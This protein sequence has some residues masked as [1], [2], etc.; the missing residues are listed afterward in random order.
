MTK[1]PPGFAVPLAAVA[2][3]LAVTRDVERL[4][5]VR[6][7]RGL[8]IVVGVVALWLVPAMAMH[9][10]DMRSMIREELFEQLSGTGEYADV[11]HQP[12]FYLIPYLFLK[13]APWSP[14]LVLGLRDVGKNALAAPRSLRDD[15]ALLLACWLVGGLV[16]FLFPATKRPDHL[17]P[18]YAPA[19][20]LAGAALWPWI[21]QQTPPVSARVLDGVARLWALGAGA[22]AL[23]LLPATRFGATASHASPPGW[24]FGVSAL[25]LL[26]M[27]HALR[28]SATPRARLIA[29][30]AAHGLATLV[31]SHSLTAPA[32]EADAPV[33]RAFAGE[34]ARH[35]GP[36]PILFVETHSIPLQFLLARNVPEL[37]RDAV[38]TTLAGADAPSWLIAPETVLSALVAD[39]T[40][41][42][43]VARW[44]IVARSSPRPSRG[45]AVLALVRIAPAAPGAAGAAEATANENAAK[46]PV[47]D[48][49]EPTNATPG[50]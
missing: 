5:S 2:L 41:G 44:P 16:V 40:V 42:D 37:S 46:R 24:M 8:A 30:L 27:A 25:A 43:R 21:G 45:G 1:G 29:A 39:P 7:M 14:A 31:F 10:D 26:P 11:K 13:L 28:P 9:F 32:R 38:A 3:H 23:V 36:A 22:F 18:M 49:R 20:L 6:V 48:P 15:G 19:A 47:V 50:T 35:V 12:F 33:V 17:L 34:V 4:R